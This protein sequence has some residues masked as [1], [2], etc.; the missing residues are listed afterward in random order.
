MVEDS[1]AM[2]PLNA[3]SVGKHGMTSVKYA[4]PRSRKFWGACSRWGNRQLE[5]RRRYSAARI[6]RDR[7]VAA[8]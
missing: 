7:A 2:G 3:T 4:E 5:V 1:G 8:A 6:W